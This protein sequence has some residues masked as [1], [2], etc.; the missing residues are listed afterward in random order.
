MIISTM[1]SK[2]RPLRTFGCF[3]RDSVIA[4]LF[5][6]WILGLSSVSIQAQNVQFRIM[7][8]QGKEH[9]TDFIRLYPD[10]LVCGPGGVR[11]GYFKIPIRNVAYINNVLPDSSGCERNP[12]PSEYM[13]LR[14]MRGAQLGAF[15]TT[16]ATTAILVSVPQALVPVAIGGGIVSGLLYLHSFSGVARLQEYRRMPVVEGF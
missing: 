16:L 14:R 7:D 13:A 9:F 2:K 3:L 1:P 11:Q 5:S 12:Y 4:S 8:I 15:W 10:T 6:Y